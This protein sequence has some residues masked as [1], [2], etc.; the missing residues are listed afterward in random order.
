MT[1]CLCGHPDTDHA[2]GEGICNCGCPAYRPTSIE[3]TAAMAANDAQHDGVAEAFLFNH[4]LRA[5]V[6][7]DQVLIETP[8]VDELLLAEGQEPADG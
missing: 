6:E 8:D 5:T 2:I 3:Y 1:H 7:G 4:Q